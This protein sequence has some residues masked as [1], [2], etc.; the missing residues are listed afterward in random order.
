MIP[1][2]FARQDF[3]SIE[4]SF[5]SQKN[6][7]QWCVVPSHAVLILYWAENGTSERFVFEKVQCYTESQITRSILTTLPILPQF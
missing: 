1:P 7:L 4:A 3:A 6:S 2:P 5:N